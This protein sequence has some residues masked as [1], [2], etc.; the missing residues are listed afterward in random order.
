MALIFAFLPHKQPFVPFHGP[1][2]AGTSF[3]C[4][5]EA[6]S[7]FSLFNSCRYSNS[8]SP[9]SPL[10]TKNMYPL[11][12]SSLILEIWINLVQFYNKRVNKFRLPHN[13]HLWCF[14]KKI[15]FCYHICS[16]I[17]QQYANSF[18]GAGHQIIKKTKLH[19]S[20]KTFRS[21]PT[22]DQEL[23]KFHA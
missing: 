8:C 7:H 6:L 13:S 18:N 20:A 1:K 3:S 22:K 19:M 21:T 14:N 2:H 9:P 4:I 11:Y 10:T 12:P 23:L 15:G 5:Y 17:Q 16:W